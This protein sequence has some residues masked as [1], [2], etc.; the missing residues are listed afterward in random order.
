M[1]HGHGVAAR[2]ASGLRITL[3]LLALAALL[4]LGGCAARHGANNTPAQTTTS[5]Q[6]GG[7]TTGGAT[8]GSG[9]AAQQIEDADQQVQNAMQGVD[10]AQNDANNADNQSTP[11]NDVP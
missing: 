3:V 7:Q 1:R 11:P 8:S 4:A 5:Q 9:S 2:G 10:N 6:T